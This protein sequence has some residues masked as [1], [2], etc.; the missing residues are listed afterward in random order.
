MLLFNLVFT[1]LVATIHDDLGCQEASMGKAILSLGSEES[2]S[3][4]VE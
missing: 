4:A 3:P 1:S 2:K